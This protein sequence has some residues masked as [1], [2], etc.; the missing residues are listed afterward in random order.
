M[1]RL[2]LAHN[3]TRFALVITAA[4][5]SL[6]LAQGMPAFE[7]PAKPGLTQAVQPIAYD[8]ATDVHETYGAF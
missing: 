7:K 6:A 8:P 3:Q 5:S 2:L 1:K 4:V